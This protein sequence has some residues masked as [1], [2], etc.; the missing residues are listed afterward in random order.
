[1]GATFT[2][3]EPDSFLVCSGPDHN[4]RDTLDPYDFCTVATPEADGVIHM[5]GAISWFDEE[6]P[7]IRDVVREAGRLGYREIRWERI[8]PETW[9]VR[10]VRI[11]LKKD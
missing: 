3:L 10:D 8:D 7:K 11:H 5:Y 2:P 1:M 9:N 4:S 6:H